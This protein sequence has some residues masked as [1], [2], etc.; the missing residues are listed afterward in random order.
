MAILARTAA[1]LLLAQL[2]AQGLDLQA[3][4]AFVGVDLG[5]LFEVLQGGGG[6]GPLAVD[7][8]SVA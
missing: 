2:A 8:P 5:G 6:I 3:D 4:S 7:G 1:S